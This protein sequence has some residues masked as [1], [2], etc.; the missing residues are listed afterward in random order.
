LIGDPRSELSDQVNRWNAEGGKESSGDDL[1]QRTAG[2]TE[3]AAGHNG[4]VT[5]L[6]V[7]AKQYKR[8]VCALQCGEVEEEKSG[9]ERERERVRRKQEREKIGRVRKRGERIGGRRLGAGGRGGRFPRKARGVSLLPA[10][11]G[12]AATGRAIGKGTPH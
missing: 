6:M 8:V 3:K 12:E 10:S 4:F 9:G 2:R 7:T 11:E 1:S 5:R